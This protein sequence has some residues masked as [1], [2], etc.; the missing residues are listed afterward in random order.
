MEQISLEIFFNPETDWE[1][2][3]YRILGGIKTKTGA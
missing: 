1:M 2:N 3:Q